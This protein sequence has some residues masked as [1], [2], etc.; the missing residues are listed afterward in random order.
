MISLKTTT[1]FDNT[2]IAKYLVLIFLFSCHNSEGQNINPQII[3]KNI[4][5]LI[6]ANNLNSDI[7]AFDY[8]KNTR[9][10]S[11]NCNGSIILEGKKSVIVSIDR[12]PINL[13]GND[14]IKYLRTLR[15]GML[16]KIEILFSPPE[17]CFQNV[18]IINI[19]SKKNKMPKLF[20]YVK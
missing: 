7:T 15:S 14:L 4:L 18:G 5:I 8:L 6:D 3:N 1:L 2:R 20:R 9:G 17:K 10:L 19:F 12:Q 16:E 13:S 11:I